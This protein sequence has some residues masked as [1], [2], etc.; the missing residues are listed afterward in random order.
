MN[1]SDQSPAGPRRKR[2]RTSQR[3]EKENQLPP[4]R[5]RLVSHAPTSHEGLER[6]K[7]LLEAAM[8]GRGASEEFLSLSS[9]MY[10]NWKRSGAVYDE[11]CFACKKSDDIHPCI[12]CRRQYHESCRPKSSVTVDHGPAKGWYCDICVVRNWHNEPPTLTPPASPPLETSRVVEEFESGRRDVHPPNPLPPSEAVQ[13]SRGPQVLS[14]SLSLVHSTP[15][16]HPTASQNTSQASETVI[17]RPAATPTHTGPGNVPV[18][19]ARSTD[20]DTYTSYRPVATRRSRYTTLPTEVDSALRVLYSELETAAELRQQIGGLEGQVNQL[21][22]D[23]SLRDREL[24]MTQKALQSAR[25]SQSELAQLRLEASQ[26]QG[27]VEEAATLR[28][29]KQQLEEE[30]KSTRTQMDEMSKTLQQWKQKLSSLLA[31]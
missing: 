1:D 9:A 18:R 16:S 10:K 31:D 25:A 5:T 29:E 13:S 14:P 22:Q 12:T 4:R 11:F 6:F 7:E 15:T 21:R 30:L 17:A 19:Q 2:L 8:D 23:L 28:A 20:I 3:H 24:Q 26:R 27:S